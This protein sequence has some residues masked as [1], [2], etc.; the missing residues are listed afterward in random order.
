MTGAERQ[1]RWKDRHP[2][3]AALSSAVYREKNANK[4]RQW[5]AD[6]RA[7]R[8]AEL[9]KLRLAAIAGTA[10]AERQSRREAT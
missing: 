1:R 4:F 8:R 7:R 2:E 5:D 10:N 3:R 6:Y 9:M